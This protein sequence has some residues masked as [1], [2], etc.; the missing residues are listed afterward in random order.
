[1]RPEKWRGLWFDGSA[2]IFPTHIGSGRGDEVFDEGFPIEL[3]YY[4]KCDQGR[5]VRLIE[6]VSALGLRDISTRLMS[7]SDLTNNDDNDPHS[8]IR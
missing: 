6:Q 5:P 7:S 3:D 8:Q 4:T 2:Y 1:M